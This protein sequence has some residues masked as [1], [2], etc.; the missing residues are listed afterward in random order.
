MEVGSG[1]WGTTEVRAPPQRGPQQCSVRPA[2]AARTRFHGLFQTGLR[3]HAHLEHQAPAGT[4]A[5]P[6]GSEGL[7]S[8][9]RATSFLSLR[10]PAW[11][12]TLKRAS[13]SQEA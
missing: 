8:R 11:L 13:G 10:S 7:L 9:G 4:Q 6:P 3:T 5:Q 1:S 12:V 2:S